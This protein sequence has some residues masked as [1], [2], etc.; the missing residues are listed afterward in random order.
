MDAM[1]R[2]LPSDAYMT[3]FIARLRALKDA[4]D[5]GLAQYDLIDSYFRER[6]PF[7][8]LLSSVPTSGRQ[9]RQGLQP[10]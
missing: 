9:A 7:L 3:E 1:Q 5:I 6:V 2:E 10:G 8:H 4:E